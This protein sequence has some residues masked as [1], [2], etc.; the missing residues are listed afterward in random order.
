M[1][2]KNT[3]PYPLENRT[4]WENFWK[5][6]WFGSMPEIID[7]F[8]IS[9]RLTPAKR[10]QI[11]KLINQIINDDCLSFKIGK[12]GDIEIRADQKDYRKYDK[13]YPVFESTSKDIIS[14]LEVEY[15]E[16]YKK[17]Y[18]EKCDNITIA[19]VGN[20]YSY[21]G[22]YYLYVVVKNDV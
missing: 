22:Y 1:K 5:S 3:R 17:L 14:D 4:K 21:D 7:D 8:I 15:I 11:T 20:M 16:K 13:L 18:P 6:L 9:G 19:R 12:T 10:G 2:K